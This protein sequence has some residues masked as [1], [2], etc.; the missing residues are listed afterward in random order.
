MTFLR[1]LALV[2]LVTTSG[3]DEDEPSAPADGG[4]ETGPHCSGTSKVACDQPSGR[5]E[6]C[7]CD[8]AAQCES[9]ACEF[10]KYCVKVC[11]WK[12]IPIALDARCNCGDACAEGSRCL[13]VCP[14]DAYCKNVGVE[15]RCATREAK[16]GRCRSSEQCARGLHCE[17]PAGLGAGTCEQYPGIGEPCDPRTGNC[18]DGL[19]CW[20]G[21]KAPRKTGETCRNDYDCEGYARCDVACGDPAAKCCGPSVLGAPCKSSGDCGFP[22]VFCSTVSGTC[23]KIADRDGACDPADAPAQC[24]RDDLTYYSSTCDP[25]TRTCVGGVCL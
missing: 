4:A 22:G 6:G 21:C 2:L 17:I 12:P 7:V 20:N 24:P 25:K 10:G 3:C 15:N 14:G 18:S 5:Q 11:Q 9:G 13:E 23:K 19:F 8:N 16:G 1:S